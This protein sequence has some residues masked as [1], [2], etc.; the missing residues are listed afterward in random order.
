MCPY[1]DPH[2][3]PHALQEAVIQ[4]AEEAAESDDELDRLFNKGRRRGREGAGGRSDYENKMAVENFL[5]QMEVAVE[6]D[7]K[8]YEA[9][10]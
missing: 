9:G 3:P 7:Q 6:E 5:A 1:R 8:D 4:A 2:P 10:G